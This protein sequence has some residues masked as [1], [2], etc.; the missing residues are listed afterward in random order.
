MRR[1]ACF[2]CALSLAHPAIAAGAYPNRPVRLICPSVPGG[3]TDLTARIVAQ[4]LSEDWRYQVI[5]DNRGGASGVIGT[6]LAARAAPDGH[7]MLLGTMSNLAV[8][9]AFSKVPYDPVKDFAPVSLVV[10]APQLLAVHP[11][12]PA[13]TTR[14][15]IALAKAK[16]G[17]YAYASSGAGSTPHIAIEL[18]KLMAGIDVLGVQYKASGPAI[19]ELISGQVQMMMTGVLALSPHVKAGR[20]RALAITSSKRNAAL[21]DLP[22][23]AESGVPGFDVQVW[24]AVFMPAGTP[25]Q[26][27]ADTNG[28]IR[29]MLE[30]PELRARLIGQGADPQSSTPEELGALVKNDVAR[31]VKVVKA[32]GLANIER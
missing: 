24:F 1:A 21:P 27:I 32:T 30:A 28:R 19:T 23:V 14:E 20:V 15:L 11:Q 13:K 2:A 18:F 5:V 6:E 29:K 3:T 22:T 4:K 17:Q 12:L 7:T 9:P 8:N 31:W 25:R 26:F 16:P 10:T